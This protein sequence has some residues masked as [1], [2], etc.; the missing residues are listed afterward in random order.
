MERAVGDQFVGRRAELALLREKL[1]E[2]RAGRPRFVQVEGPPGI[3]KTALVDRFLRTEPDVQVLR[4][5][6]DEAETLLSFGVFDQLTRFA[7]RPGTVQLGAPET[8]EDA[9][10]AGMQLLDLLG[11]LE[12]RTPLVLVVDDAHWVDAP[13][14][15]ALIFA[16]RR[17][18]ADRVLVLVVV[19]EE[20]SA[21]LPASLR[22]LVS[23][24]HGAVLRLAGLDGDDLRRLGLALG[25]DGFSA[26]AA[27]RLRS[28]TAGSPLYARALLRESG[29]DSWRRGELPLSSPR[30]FSVL[31]V[32]RLAE[33]SE[34][35]RRLVDAASVLGLRSALSL[36]VRLSG[37]GDPLPALDEAAAAGV[38]SAVEEPG[39]LAVA[40]PHPLVRS[41]VYGALG[42]AR[43]A[44][45]HAVAATLVETE[46]AVLHHRVAAATQADAGL[47]DELAG[48]AKREAAR[49]AWTGAAAHLV[50]ASRLSPTPVER[51]Q[52]LLEAVNWML[53]TGDA[54]QAATFE[55]EIGGFAPTP[56]RDSVLGYLASVTRG[57]AAAEGLL[58]SAWERCDPRADPELAATIAVQNTVHWYGRLDGAATVEWGRRALALSPPDAPTRPLA[59][60]YCGYGLAFTGRTAEAFDT[61]LAADARSGD[62]G[63][64]WLQ[65]R[66][67]RGVLRL[68]E[69]DLAGARADLASVAGTALEVGRLNTAAFGFAYLARAD[70]VAGRWDDAAVH[71]ERGMA[72]NEESDNDF[73]QSVVQALAASV[74]AARGDWATARARA[75]AATPP[76]GGYERAVVAAAM[77][78]AQ[79]AAARG[80]HAAVLAAFAPVLGLDHREGVDEPGFWPWQDLYAEALV[81]VGRAGDADRFLRPHEELAARRGRRSAM[82]R[83]ARARGRTEAALDR[84]DGA[85]AAFRHGLGLLDGLPM[86]FERALLELAHGQFL[87]RQGRR[88]AAATALSAARATFEALGAAPYRDRGDAELAACG[89]A[90]AS[91]SGVDPA[92]LTSQELA[93]A[94]LAASGRSNREVAAELV[95]SVKTVEF[96]LRNTY[97]KLGLTSR[98]QLADRL[99]QRAR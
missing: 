96:H 85:E 36:A 57:P 49:E 21:L 23:G 97:Q 83:L 20:E 37:V 42:T 62:T 68:V 65:P 66:S 44:R 35:A 79:L 39:E 59:A 24:E 69:D 75:A 76:P 58:R 91:R 29:P 81:G 78:Y 84:P 12:D 46:A 31:V 43:R 32:R 33:C 50:A 55:P 2:V 52:R 93:V 7:G 8:A 48:F 95:V 73:T 10:R 72:V 86:P 6:G 3:G 22:R 26:R 94:R 99:P 5:S 16:L 11:N 25:F 77:A 87:R 56:L 61:V 80:E 90:P 67:A 89:L 15:R 19:R 64:R 14:L 4:C 45:L 88:K 54:A 18:V 60:T 41:A 13:S 40:F 92:R 9:A 82:A 98:R 28:E 71:A 74:P 38:L 63:Y 30:S 53:L 70:Y 1:A 17:L 34:P 51:E 27:Q 47:A